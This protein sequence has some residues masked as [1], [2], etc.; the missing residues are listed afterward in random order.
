MMLLYF[1]FLLAAE[2]IYCRANEVERD[3][4]EQ[5]IE[6]LEEQLKYGGKQF[7]TVPLNSELIAK[8]KQ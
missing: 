4:L 1:G 2:S 5:R 6:K 7:Q 8:A 3:T